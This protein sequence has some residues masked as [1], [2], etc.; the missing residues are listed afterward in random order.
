MAL[1]KR[2][3]VV[4]QVDILQTMLEQDLA[5]WS[6]QPSVHPHQRN[7]IQQ[8][9]QVRI[10]NASSERGDN[11]FEWSMVV[12]LSQ[13]SFIQHFCCCQWLPCMCHRS[14]SQWPTFWSLRW[15]E[16]INAVGHGLIHFIYSNETGTD[17][18]ADV[19]ISLNAETYNSLASSSP[20]LSEQELMKKF[21]HA[22]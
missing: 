16:G 3:Q 15:F 13:D 4:S 10:M 21:M 2:Q 14:Y 22:L 19:L 20:A 11:A 17:A 8:C 7:I 18:L 9:A 12:L 1:L 5:P 6:L